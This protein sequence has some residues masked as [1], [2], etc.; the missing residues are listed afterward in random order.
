MWIIVGDYLNNIYENLVN[1]MPSYTSIYFTKLYFFMTVFDYIGTYL[2]SKIEKLMLPHAFCL[3]D[4]AAM[5][6]HNRL[7]LMS[8]FLQF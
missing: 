8:V 3:K 5:F 6:T 2:Q 1:F 4:I 7:P